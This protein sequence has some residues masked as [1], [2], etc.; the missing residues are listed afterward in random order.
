MPLW[1]VQKVHAASALSS[2]H[3]NVRVCT[4]LTTGL[5]LANKAAS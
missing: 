2:M 1:K 4:L 5:W 3:A